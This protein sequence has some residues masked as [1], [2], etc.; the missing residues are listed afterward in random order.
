MV[1]DTGDIKAI[2]TF[3][4]RDTT[5]NPSLITAAAQLPQH[6]EIVDQTLLQAKRDAVANM[7]KEAIVSLAFDRLAVAFG[8]RILLS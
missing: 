4:P 3:K 7:T 5:P 1:A 2:A 8:L 6:Q